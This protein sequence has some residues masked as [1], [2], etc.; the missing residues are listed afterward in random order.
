MPLLKHVAYWRN[1][2]MQMGGKTKNKTLLIWGRE[3]GCKMKRWILSKRA[4]KQNSVFQI[5]PFFQTE[6]DVATHLVQ[7]VTSFMYVC[8]FYFLTADMGKFKPSLMAIWGLLSVSLQHF[9]SHSHDRATKAV[10]PTVQIHFFF[11]TRLPIK[12]FALLERTF[13]K[14]RPTLTNSKK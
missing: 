11:C 3:G 6:M 12:P 9:Y 2:H 1:K 7:A 10:Q 13:L 4:K 5:W 8:I 14:V